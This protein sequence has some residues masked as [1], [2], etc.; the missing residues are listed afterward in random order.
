MLFFCSRKTFC[1]LF[2]TMPLSPE[3]LHCVKVFKPTV[4]KSILKSC[5][6]F[7]NLTNTPLFLI[8]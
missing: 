6:F 5:F 4:G 2:R 3:D 1:L 8:P 7:G